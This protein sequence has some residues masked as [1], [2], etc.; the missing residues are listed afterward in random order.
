[1]VRVIVVLQLHVV[2]L[3][4]DTAKVD[5]KFWRKD[6]NCLL[7]CSSNQVLEGKHPVRFDGMTSEHFVQGLWHL[8]QGQL[9]MIQSRS[10]IVEVVAQV[11]NGFLQRAAV[12][13]ALDV[14]L[15]PLDQCAEVLLC[16][17]EV[18]NVLDEERVPFL[19]D[20]VLVVLEYLSKSCSS[21]R[22][23]F[24]KVEA[25]LFGRIENI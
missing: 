3:A 6:D 22:I 16:E 10:V 21:L 8:V 11:L 25:V 4:T 23:L 18:V 15:H 7:N 9:Q 5:S 20:P 14:A 17:T 12:F 1:M 2:V 24:E 13:G 19:A